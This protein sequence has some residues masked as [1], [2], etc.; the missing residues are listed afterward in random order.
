[1]NRRGICLGGLALAAMPS[2]AQAECSRAGG[3]FVGRLLFLRYKQ[4][5]FQLKEPFGFID[6]CGKRWQA[7]TEAL[8]DGASIP[9]IAQLFTGDPYSGPYLDAAVVHDWYC[10]V[11]T[12]PHVAVHQMFY[13]GMIAAGVGAT[14]AMSMYVGVCWRGPKWDELTIQNNR[15]RMQSNPRSFIKPPP[16]PQP[17]SPPPAMAAQEP[18]PP[19]PDQNVLEQARIYR[20]QGQPSLADEALFYYERQ[21]AA[22]DAYLRRQAEI[23]RENARYLREAEERRLLKVQQE[24]REIQSFR[25]LLMQTGR[26]RKSLDEI[27]EIARDF[28]S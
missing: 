18:P 10:A 14:L 19:S 25:E 16:P 13:N 8:T 27:A 17:P 28:P 21:A 1:M 26:G 4:G 6:G 9:S 2:I 12:E 20:Q 5:I 3:R 23:E 11:R 7:P 22:Y 24:Q 15:L